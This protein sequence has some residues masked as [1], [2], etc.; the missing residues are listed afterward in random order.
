MSH[1]TNEPTL[2]ITATEAAMLWQRAQLN[3]L[4]LK[5]RSGDSKFYGL[6]VD[7]YR[8]SLQRPDVANRGIETRQSVASEERETWT[9]Q[10]L[11]AATGRAG[12][13]IRLDIANNTL[14]A[15]K[16][17]NAWHITNAEAQTYIASHTK[18]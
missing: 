12:R 15:T 5:Y 16:T 4:R 13:T 9:V 11:T 8:L 3:D 18:Q 1:L 2:I 14:P 10:Q 17:A 7:V 6:L